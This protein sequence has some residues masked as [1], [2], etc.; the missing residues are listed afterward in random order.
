MIFGVRFVG[1]SFFLRDN[2]SF[3]TSTALQAFSRDGFS[4]T[5]FEQLNLSRIQTVVRGDDLHFSGLNLR[6]YDRTAT[7]QAFCDIAGVRADSI[8]DVITGLAFRFF[9]CWQYRF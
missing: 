6:R 3:P 4:A 1:D 8:V 9:N 5:L 7:L 2:T